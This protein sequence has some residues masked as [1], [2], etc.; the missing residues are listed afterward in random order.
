LI[1]DIRDMLISRFH[2][3]M[4]VPEHWDHAH[5]VSLP[6]AEALYESFITMP[7]NGGDN[8]IKYYVNW[9]DGWVDQANENSDRVL[10]IK[11]EE[12]KNELETT[13]TR[14]FDFFEYNHNTT[15]KKIISNHEKSYPRTSRP[16]AE[17][18]KLS[19]RKHSTF[20]S[21]QVGG[22]QNVLTPRHL[23][24]IEKYAGGLL[25]KWGY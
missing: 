8:A 3:I 10:I 1:R 14:V 7:A 18:F 20:R 5:L 22:W 11:F 21:G 6:E 23:D 25:S 13:L 19:G 2:H 16:L 9:I 4:A 24:I 12:M 15:V 17:S